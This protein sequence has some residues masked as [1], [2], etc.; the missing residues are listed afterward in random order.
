MSEEIWKPIPGFNDWYEA[1]SHGRVRSKPRTLFR[2]DGTTQARRGT[3]LKPG[4]SRGYQVVVLCNDTKRYTRTVHSLVALAFL[5]PPNPGDHVR[6][7]DGS[8]DNNRIENLTYGTR[9]ENT[10]DSVAHGTHNMASVTHCPRGHEYAEWNLVAGKVKQGRRM[11][12]ACTNSWAYLK[13]KNMLNE[14]NWKAYSDKYYE[15]FL[16]EVAA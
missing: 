8:R 5:G 6:H 4:Q 9:S 11:C 12:R 15:G 1:S 7:L 13:G 14:D 3:I 10:H 16:R 2:S